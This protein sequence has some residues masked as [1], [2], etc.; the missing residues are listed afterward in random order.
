[1][2]S[3]GFYLLFGLLLCACKPPAEEDSGDPFLRY[4]G[5]ASPIE[6]DEVDGVTTHTF[7]SSDGPM[8]FREKPFR[9]A[10]REGATDDL[11]I[12]LQGGGACW[13]EFCLAIDSAPPGIPLLEVLNADLEFNPVKDW[14]VA[15]VPYCDASLF[16]GDIDVDEDEDG[17]PD[18]FHRGLQNIS[19][20]VDQASQEFPSPSRILLAG[21]SGGGYG[22]I[23]ASQVV[24]ARFPDAPIF[25]VQD[26][27]LGIGKG[28]E[29]PEFVWE[30]VDEFNARHL[31]EASCGDCLDSGHLTPMVEWILENDSNIWVSAFSTYSDLIIAD[32]FLQIGA[33]AH[34]AALLEQS[35]LIRA[36]FPDRWMPFYMEGVFHTTLLGSVEG[37]LGELPE[38]GSVLEGV[39]ELGSMETTE[40]NGVLFTDWMAGMLEGDP[41]WQPV[42]E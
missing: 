26:S 25:I 21:S 8:C 31:I 38:E 40:L 28:M 6:S 27:G 18:R 22:T 1:M 41:I 20:A 24:R 12:F 36:S 29:D 42:V 4:L 13:S 33:T 19:A 10:T 7:S 9:M 5:A 2:H 15:Y 32:I 30:L 23:V 37:I 17:K 3:K 11:V 16:A 39:V 14:D 34:R 35:E